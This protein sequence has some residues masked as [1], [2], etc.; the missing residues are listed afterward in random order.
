MSKLLWEQR[1]I[2]G[3]QGRKMNKH[4]LYHLGGRPLSSVAQLKSGY[5]Y[6]IAYTHLHAT[7]AL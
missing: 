7:V 4:P 5:E 6:K 2:H 1:R 3:K